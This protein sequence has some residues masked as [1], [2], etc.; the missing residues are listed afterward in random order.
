[1]DKRKFINNKASAGQIWDS[2]E[3]YKLY[4]FPISDLCK[5]YNL[6]HPDSKLTARKNY[7]ESFLKEFGEIPIIDLGSS[8]IAQ[9]L[10]NIKNINQLSERTLAQIKCQLNFFFKWLVHEEII[11]IN[12]LTKIKFKRNIPPKRPRCVLNADEIQEIL[13]AAQSFESIQL[14][15]YLFAVI[16]TGARRSEVANLTWE[17]VDLEKGFLMFRDTKNGSDRKLKMSP[18]LIKTISTQA[19]TSNFVFSNKKHNFLNRSCIERMMNEFKASYPFKKD[20]HIHDLRHSFAYNFLRKG[21][22]MYQLQAIL[23]HKSIQMTVDLYGNLKSHDIDMPSP[24]D[25]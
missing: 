16:Q 2:R 20:W 11:S 12:P 18:S 8:E 14:Y 19:R 9:W 17:D 5:I 13:V 24:Y 21:G 3:Y 4:N 22:E 7:Y 6:L 23:G 1:M 10:Q 15:S 25:F